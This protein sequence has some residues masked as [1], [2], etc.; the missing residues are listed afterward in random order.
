[1]DEYINLMI[2]VFKLR[3]LIKYFILIIMALVLLCF[4]V[5]KIDVNEMLKKEILISQSKKEEKE[6]KENTNSKETSLKKLELALLKKEIP[7]MKDDFKLDLKV[8]MEEK[9]GNNGNNE[10]NENN[11]QEEKQNEII[12][13]P[14]ENVKTEIIKT[15]VNPKSTNEFRGVKINNSTSYSLS[16]DMLNPDNLAINKNKI[17]I[18]HT[19]T[20]ESYTQ[21]E[22]NMYEPSG[23][24]RC[25][26]LNYTVVKVGEEL[27]KQLNSYG[28]IALQ[29]KTCH[30]YPAYNGSYSRSLKTVEKMKK[31][32]EEADI[33]I[34]LHRDAIADSTYA[35]KVKIGD[36]Y[37]SQLMFVIGS[38]AANKEHKNWEDNLKFAI[39]V[40][41]KA[42][43]LYPG[44]FK[45]IIV[46]NS[47]YNQHVSKAACIIEVGAT[48][49]TLEE[50]IGAMKYLAKVI[51]EI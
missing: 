32:N 8:A 15:N 4:L 1:M 7:I 20:S 28:Y 16:E 23:D 10:N 43:E 3:E 35:P 38:N 51:N 49:N 36:E 40:Q 13:H 46:R 19:H 14:K 29:D 41:Q 11:E 24:F 37:V 25:L 9:N 30:D 6:E 45:P 17:L 26:D 34:D 42:N 33:V 27:K 39:K 47:E 2:K 22:N 12:E 48:G 50:S 31:E 18:Y 44:L 21:T 5:N